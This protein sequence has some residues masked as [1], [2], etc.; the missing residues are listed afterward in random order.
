MIN[1]NPYEIAYCC[2]VEGMHEKAAEI[3]ISPWALGCSCHECCQ[4]F[5]KALKYEPSNEPNTVGKGEDK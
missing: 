5:D 3:E 4:D 2:T 1:Y